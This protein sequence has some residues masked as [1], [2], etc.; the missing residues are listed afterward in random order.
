MGVVSCAIAV[1]CVPP[2]YFPMWGGMFLPAKKGVTEEDYYY[3]EYTPK[4]REEGL[5]LASSA[6][7]FE[8]RS[9]RGMRRLQ[10]E[11]GMGPPPDA[12]AGLNGVSNGQGHV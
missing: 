10:K 7:C 5:H 8:S 11:G 3:T 12:K 1:L 4:E 9:Q 2:I 6:F